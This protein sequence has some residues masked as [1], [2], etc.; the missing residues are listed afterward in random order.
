MPRKSSESGG[1]G[2][3]SDGRIGVAVVGYG[4]WGPNLVR[5]FMGTKG[6]AVRYVCDL[7]DARREAAAQLYPSVGM[8]A[9]LN[10]VLDDESVDLVIVA[11]P[12]STHAALAI[13][14]LQAGKHVLVEKP[15]ATTAEDAARICAA[16][17]TAGRH[18][19]VDHTFVF[20][21]AVRKMR[22]LSEDG[23]LGRLLYYDSTRINLGIIQRD[24]DVIWDL[25][26]HD[27]SIL[28]NLLDGMM[29]ASVSCVG[30]SHYFGEQ[31]ELAYVSLKY[32]NGFL[33][34]IHVNWIAPVKIRQILLGGDRRMLVYDD[35]NAS[36]KVKVYD[37]GVAVN[38]GEDR[39]K[40]L[41]QYRDG[42]M[43]AP[44]IEN[45][46]AL[47]LEAAHIVKVLNGREAPIVPGSA[48]ARVVRLLEAASRS[49]ASSRPVDVEPL[50]LEAAS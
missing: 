9:D 42:D 28:D 39:Y 29:P 11:T 31:S 24:C 7:S 14:A 36:E 41:V 1:A 17:K 30:A 10:A 4:Y 49:L 12:P 50:E 45:S 18:V 25:L 37:R 3:M 2:M 19:F 21:P 47:S 6:A 20:T 26:P 34:H 38:D 33:A 15:I 22:S 35:I 48:G 8:T 43:L 27:L 46:E 5:N 44:K 13:R 32:P 40:R 16:A 23:Y